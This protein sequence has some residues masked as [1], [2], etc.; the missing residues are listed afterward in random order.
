MAFKSVEDRLDEHAALIGQIIVSQ[1]A[2]LQ[3]MDRFEARLNTLTDL[4]NKELENAA[5]ERENAAK[6]RAAMNKRW[7]EITLKMGSFVEDI[8]APNIPRIGRKLFG[9][10]DMELSACRYQRKHS[11]DPAR[12]E[13]FDFVYIASN[14]WIL[15]ETKATP[16]VAHVDSFLERIKDLPGFFPECGNRPLYPC[17]S[18]LNL[19][20]D[21]VRYCT[22]AGVYALAL[23]DETVSVLNFEQLGRHA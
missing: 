19:G 7:G 13:E 20:E 18:S 23:G 4:V 2:A 21:I 15:N 5:R 17:F 6:E 11:I 3:R 1:N 8:I 14:G 12:R 22:K 9:L 16:R 10:S